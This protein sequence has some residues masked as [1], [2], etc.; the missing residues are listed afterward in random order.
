M[1]DPNASAGPVSEVASLSRLKR[2]RGGHRASATKT[3]TLALST[4][5]KMKS[6]SSTLAGSEPIVELQQ[7]VDTLKAKVSIIATLDEQI[8]DLVEES[9]IE[10]EVDT[11][12]S[13]L[14][15]IKLVIRQVD[16]FLQQKSGVVVAPS[17]S[18]L[19]VSD[20]VQSN[21]STPLISTPGQ[22]CTTRLP[23]L[24]LPQFSGDI[25][26]WPTFWDSFSAAVHS[27]SGLAK[28]EKFNYLRSLVR[29][30]AAESIGG[31]AL[32]SANYEEAVDILTTRFG[33]T[34]RIVRKHMELLLHVD[35]VRT[36]DLRRLRRL[37]DTFE[38]NIR[39]LRS[40]GVKSEAYGALLAPVLMSRL[41]DELRL[42]ISR[43]VEE[44]NWELDILLHHIHGELRARERVQLEKFPNKGP[45]EK[46][47][48]AS[49]THG[50]PSESTAT[51]SALF[52]AATP[53]RCA[54]C[55]QDHTMNNCHV[56][57][58]TG[59]RKELL[60][61]K[62]R[63]FNCA[64]PNHLSRAC[65]SKARC[66]FCEGKHHSSI[67]DS[68]RDMSG[69]RQNHERHDVALFC[70]DSTQVVLLQTAKATICRPDKPKQCITARVILD[71]GSQRSFVRE[72]ICTQLKLQSKCQETVVVQ[73]FGSTGGSPQVRAVVMVCLKLRD[74]QLTVPMLSV[75]HISPPVQT[76]YPSK[77]AAAFPQFKGLELADDC[78][79]D[80][81]VD[82]LIGADFYWQ[83]VS[84][85]V[86]RGD[87]GPV[88][89]STRLG[90]VLSGPMPM[91][92]LPSPA[93]VNLMHLHVLT[94]T[95]PSNTPQLTSTLE[96]FWTLESI[97][98]LPKELSVYE[99][100]EQRIRFANTRYV[101]DLPWKECHAALPDN[102]RLSERRLRSLLERLK[103]EP[104]VCTAYQAVFAEQLTLGIIE[105]VAQSDPNAMGKAHYLPHHPVVRNDKK[106]T[107]VRVVFDASAKTCQGPSLNE[108]LYS[109]PAM[110]ENILDIIIRFR[111]HRVAVVGDIEK[112]FLMVELAESDRN[113]VRFL[114]VDDPFSESPQVLTYRFTRVVF[115]LTCSPF[116][117]N[118]TLRHHINLYAD[119]PD[120][121]A[122]FLENTYVDDLIN[123]ADDD[124][125]AYL[126]YSK[127]KSRLAVGGFN[128]RKF[129]SNSTALIA[130]IDENERSLQSLTP[131]AVEQAA[132]PVSTDDQSYAKSS[133]GAE[134]A[135]LLDKVLGIPWDRQQDELV[136]N[137][138][139]VFQE[140][141]DKPLTKRQVIA[142]ASQVFDPV[143]FLSPLV[144]PLKKFFQQICRIKI[145]WDEQLTP[146][147][148]ELWSSL[149]QELQSCQPIRIP[150]CYFAAVQGDIHAVELHGFCDASA[151]AYAAVVYLAIHTESGT[152]VQF[153]TSKSRVAPLASQTIPRLEL[154]SA[155]VLARLI[156]RVRKALARYVSV[157]RIACWTDSMI[158]LHWIRGDT[159]EWKTFVQNRVVEVRSLVP[160]SA[161][162][163][164]PGTLNP[165]D[166]PSRGVQPSSF[167]AK[168]W[169]NGPPWLAEKELV[170]TESR[171]D[172]VV[173]Q[174]AH[175]ELKR[176]PTTATLATTTASHPSI[177]QI[178][179]IE[180]FSTFSRLVRVTAY[181]RKFVTILQLRRTNTACQPVISAVDLKEAEALWIRTC[182]AQLVADSNFEKLSHEFGIF[183]DDQGIRRCG[184]RLRNAALTTAQKH[185]ALLPRDHPI[186]AMIVR[187]CHAAV[188]HS[189]VNETLTELRSTYW[190]VRGR[191]FVRTIV[192]GC[193]HCKRVNTKPYAASTSAQLPSER[194]SGEEAFRN[195]GVDFAGPL[196]VNEGGSKVKA[197]VALFTCA[198]S[199]AVHLELVSD[200]TT[201]A[202]MRCF[203]R[204]VARR[205]FPCFVISD[206]GKTFEAAA[207]ELCSI[208]QSAECQQFS[209]EH[210]IQWQFNVEKAPW[211]GGFFERLVQSVKRCLRKVLGN[212]YVSGEELVTVLAEVEC[213]LNSR[214]LTF[215]STEEWT[216]PLTPSHLLLGRRLRSMP[217]AEHIPRAATAEVVRERA[218]HLQQ[219]IRHSWTRWRREYLLELRN[220][221][222]Q[223]FNAN[224]T[225]IRVGDV[226]LIEDENAK[227]QQWPLGLVVELIPGHDGI[228]RAAK[229]KTAT[230]KKGSV[231]HLKRPI[232]RLY[233]LE[234][235]A[236]E[237]VTVPNRQAP[238]NEPLQSVRP[239]RAAAVQAAALPMQL[240]NRGLI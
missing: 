110:T 33:N 145:A 102:H 91:S 109:G 39:S 51:A 117:L 203:R 14:A 137:I 52:T 16:Y 200:L 62:G 104:L 129:Q 159:R 10:T 151:D 78:A 213:T 126:L 8:L 53:G 58:D 108:C 183:V 165:A 80:A 20:Q 193:Q 75:P 125:T 82:I 153:V 115:G 195:V 212:A 156:V 140:V 118:A 72:D 36:T 103:K 192:R 158:A 161:W 44:E 34:K 229:V 235:C 202:F 106:T 224:A 2:K 18:Q 86:V 219:L 176:Q 46:A 223:Q 73:P 83:V 35:P 182:Q 116:L 7:F 112:A 3:N 68:Q 15:D 67:C 96:K 226:V 38:S 222:R 94:C 236:E 9:E 240:R 144:L 70:G 37:Y 61:S 27:Q 114:W 65:S 21:T 178:I 43:E 93:A 149:L 172:D 173:I 28:V 113:A 227:R 205:G 220:A 133:L 197:Y 225:P 4:L 84:G 221:H 88:A 131:P 32:T 141:D 87:A 167:D 56:I 204:F 5:G 47:V 97:G 238:E 228:A 71:S 157:S 186:T 150:R 189:G 177:H 234:V 41:P 69:A 163:H 198:V 54:Y 30:E 11:A 187:R 120:F 105:P 25:M 214:P 208:A 17:P 155:L 218:E 132:E 12:D 190:I 160:S 19:S 135:G 77:A 119:D 57:T 6:E 181:V 50:S 13:F 121:V 90:W 196:Y 166:L 237:A 216:E 231:T 29:G 64:K 206:H 154:L 66:T 170:A 169:L 142:L 89:L 59:R 49:F 185:P 85:K 233:P 143:G 175:Q 1:T 164:C 194:V 162:S 215:L 123:G 148:Q 100:F 98:I 152:H 22:L 55:N 40:L 45:E 63:C 136:I 60:K 139:Q 24:E 101:V 128:A 147:L 23:K 138:S 179:D 232:Q 122:S 207:R 188:L 180:R 168:L 124:D 81:T 76:Q 191:Q 184:G 111:H 95:T 134:E 31:L 26:Q 146:S 171:D 127:M 217:D 99:Q 230:P 210:H 239:Q 107:K 211:W 42:I 201:E 74:G 92:V 79:G 174:E 209:A 199:R 130:R 48:S